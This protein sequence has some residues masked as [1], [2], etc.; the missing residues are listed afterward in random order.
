M[1]YLTPEC[2]EKVNFIECAK[3]QFLSHY[4]YYT[5]E[6]YYTNEYAISQNIDLSKYK[7]KRI[8]VVG[9]GP[10][11]N[12]CEWNPADYDYIFSCNHFYLHPKLQN[13]D[14]AVICPEIDIFEEQFTNYINNSKTIFCYENVDAN[15]KFVKSMLDINRAFLLSLR[16]NLK[17]GTASRL[18]VLATILEPSVVH[19]VGVDGLPKDV[20]KTAG[21]DVK[22]SFEPGKVMHSRYSYQ[23][24]YNEYKDLWNYL[25]NDIGRNIRFKNLGHGHP[26]N[27]STEFNIT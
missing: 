18:L 15:P 6:T 14:L 24:Y 9:G 17:T 16:K 13:V 21:C 7:N 20:K 5:G 25:I 10:T 22:H 19:V 23:F 4:S 12:D 2:R 1:K 11:T 8:L 3:K 26:F 27:I